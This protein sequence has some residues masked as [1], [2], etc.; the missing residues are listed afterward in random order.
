LIKKKKIVDDS[1]HGYPSTS[2]AQR[3][4]AKLPAIPSKSKLTLQEAWARAAEE[5]ETI[6]EEKRR[7]ILTK[8]E[9]FMKGR[10]TRITVGEAWNIA[11]GAGKSGQLLLCMLADSR[12]SLRKH[13]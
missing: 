10:T 5:R 11:G 7:K 9:D 3:P 6:E 2:A 13:Q 1:P 8:A 4:V 12:R